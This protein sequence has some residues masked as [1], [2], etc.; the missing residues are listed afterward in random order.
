MVCC[1]RSNNM[2][3]LY[4]TQWWY[5]TTIAQQI[6]GLGSVIAYTISCIAALYAK[7]RKL[8][9]L[10]WYVVIMALV[11]CIMLMGICSTYLIQGGNAALY[12]FLG[13]ITVGFSMFYT[14]QNK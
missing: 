5:T 3:Q 4:T 2:L 10:S 1:Y 11:N 12:L 13:L 7:K 6:S 9:N 8:L 14:Q